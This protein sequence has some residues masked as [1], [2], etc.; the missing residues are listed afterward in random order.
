MSDGNAY[1]SADAEVRKQLKRF[2]GHEVDPAGDGF[3]FITFPSPAL[4][5]TW[6]SNGYDANPEKWLD[7]PWV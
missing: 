4:R 3:F 6:K 2:G 5:T 7:G 1:K